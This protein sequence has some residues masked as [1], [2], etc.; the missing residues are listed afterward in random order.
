MKWLTVEPVPTPTMTPQK[1]T[2]CQTD[3]MVKAESRPTT[4]IEMAMSTIRRTPYRSMKAAAK[5]AMS[6][7]SSRRMASALEICAVSQPNS[8]V[9]GR[10]SAP[11]TPTA[12]EVASAVRKVT[13]TTT[14]P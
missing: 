7:K 5:G 14:Q 9:S 11:G 1:R 6:P 13:A 2:I 10:M 12:P 8:F 4:I 3:V